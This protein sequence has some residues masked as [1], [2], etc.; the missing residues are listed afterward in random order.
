MCIRDRPLIGDNF[1]VG[2][3]FFD[4]FVYDVLDPARAYLET[5]L[6]PNG[7]LPTTLDL[8]NVFLNDQITDIFGLS[9]SGDTYIAASINEDDEPAIYGA[10]SFN[11]DVFEA[12]L[13]IDFALDIP[14]LNLGVDAGS[15]INLRSTLDIDLGFG[16][17]CD[18]FFLLNS[19]DEPE[20]ALQFVAEANDFAGNFNIGGVLDV[21]ATAANT[22]G[23]VT[24]APTQVTATIGLDLFGDAGLDTGPTLSLIHI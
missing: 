3:S 17:D 22:V 4:D 6:S 1:A 8:I 11:L 15:D 14:G 21:T 13:P 7:P 19:I 18:G 12:L 10:M 5:P 24:N 20:I 2:A 23:N 9:S 16:L